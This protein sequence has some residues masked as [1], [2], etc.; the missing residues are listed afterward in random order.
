MWKWRSLPIHWDDYAVIMTTINL[1]DDAPSG[2]IL[3]FY[4]L[5]MKDAVKLRVLTFSEQIWRC[6]SVLRLTTVWNLLQCL[7]DWWLTV[8][9]RMIKPEHLPI[10]LLDG[11][12]MLF[13]K[14]CVGRVWHNI[15]VVCWALQM[16]FWL[17]RGRWHSL[18]RVTTTIRH[19]LNLLLSECSL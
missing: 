7:V 11:A 5:H 18:V 16:Q 9:L 13:N 15:Y 14:S 12:I 17:S 2:S 1:P 19:L 3:P 10:I 4:C 8:I 6:Q